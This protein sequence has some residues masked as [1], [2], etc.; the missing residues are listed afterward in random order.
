MRTIILAFLITANSLT[1]IIV[2]ALGFSLFIITNSEVS[3]ELLSYTGIYV[4]FA[5]LC[6]CE[7]VKWMKYKQA[8][9]FNYYK[10]KHFFLS[11]GV[12]L[13]AT[14]IVYGLYFFSLI[15]LLYIIYF[16]IVRRIP[17][18][19]NI[20]I[21]KNMDNQSLKSDSLFHPLPKNKP[22]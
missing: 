21:E 20:I 9:E 22:R 3:L 2:I 18:D 12:I 11:Y 5:L 7:P 17:R 14:T 13:M 6:F 15:G 4:V 19:S 16:F 8:S 10:T 1:S